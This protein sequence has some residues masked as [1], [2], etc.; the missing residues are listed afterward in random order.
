MVYGRRLRR[1]QWDY[2]SHI[3]CCWLLAADGG[4]RCYCGG[5]LMWFV[6]LFC[7]YCCCC[8]YCFIAVSVSVLVVALDIP[9]V[10]SDRDM[11]VCDC[12]SVCVCVGVWALLSTQCRRKTVPGILSIW[13][14]QLHLDSGDLTSHLPCP[15]SLNRGSKSHPNSV[16]QQPVRKI[17]RWE[18][19]TCSS[20]CI[21]RNKGNAKLTATNRESGFHIS[22]TCKPK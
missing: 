2:L 21:P 4:C 9:I 12:L 19:P 1:S 7:W 6:V 10:G 5:G 14:D 3:F 22:Y 13:R 20:T 18:A 11:L 17:E 15:C 8:C 16:L